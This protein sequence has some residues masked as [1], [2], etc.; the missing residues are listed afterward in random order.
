MKKRYR[1]R[2]LAAG[3]RREPKELIRGDCGSRRKLAA[4]YRKVS[5]RAAVARLK[6][7]IFRVIRTQGNFGP[8]KELAAG[9]KKTKKPSTRLQMLLKTKRTSEKFERKAFGLEFVKRATGMPSGL[10][11][12]RTTS[13]WKIK[14]WAL[15][16]G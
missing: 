14:D 1:G 15:W 11:R 5:Y 16:R 6:G 2:R 7:N 9:T 12:G 8:R 13:E 4:A 10:W 3:R